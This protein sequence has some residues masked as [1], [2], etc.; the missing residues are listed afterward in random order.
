MPPRAPVAASAAALVAGAHFGQRYRIVRQLG[1]GGMG[2]VYQAWDEELGIPV[3]LKVIRPEV[4]SDPYLAQDVERRFKRELLLARKVTHS[5]VVRI[6]DLGEIDRIKYITMQYVEG[7][8]LATLIQRED[9]LPVPRALRIVRGVVSG[10]CA[11]HEAGVV[12][13]DLKPANIMIDEGDEARIM[14]F[15]IARSTTRASGPVTAPPDGA[16]KLFELRQQAAL[17]IPETIQGSVVGTVEYMAPEQ[18]RGE[19]VDQRADIYALGLIMYDM[20]GGAGRAARSESALVE[21]TARMEHQPPAIRSLNPE[22]PEA[23]ER[24]VARCLQPDANAR[25]ASSRDLEADLQRL[26]DVGNLL[27]VLRRVSTRQL[28]GA[29]ALTLSL[30]A[31]TWWFSRTPV[32]S[33][34]PAPVSVL[35]AD[36]E[37]RVGDPV[38][39]D[40]LEQA[41]G[42]ALEGA[43]FIVPYRRSD[44]RRIA[45]AQLSA[46]PTLDEKTA[47]LVAVREG[48]NVVLAGG[49]EPQG[50]GYQLSI[51]ALDTAN[52]KV[53]GTITTSAKSKTDVLAAVASSA[54]RIRKVLGDTTPESARLAAAETVTSTSLEAVRDYSRAQDLLY[55]SKD[56]EAIASYK[57][58]IAKD[59]N[60]GRAYSGWAIGA[61]NLGRRQEARDAWEKAVS[62][63]DRMTER[64]K[65]RT[66]GNY[67][68]AVPHNYEKA[69]ESLSTLV[70]LYPNDRGGQV[71]I[72]ISYFYL[73]NFA[74]ALDH[75]RRSVEIAPKDVMNRANYA[76]YAMYAGDFS[77]AAKEGLTVTTQNPTVY[78]AYLPL[79]MAAIAGSDFEGARKAY[80]AMAATGA[81]GASLANLGLADL[82]LYRGRPGEAEA[83]LRQGIAADTRRQDSAGLAA[84][85]TALAE[86]LLDQ[87]KT[88]PAV[89]P[90]RR[91]LAILGQTAAAVP[92]ARVLIAAGKPQDAQALAPVLA[93][94][95]QP[96]SRAYAK[97][98]DGELALRDGHLVAAT[99]AFGAAQK[100]TDIWWARLGLGTAYA[101]ANHNA[102]A[103][104]EFELCAKRRGEATAIMLD[105]LPSIRY[106]APLQYWLGRAH[107]GV[108][109]RQ[110]AMQNY[111]AYIALRA[112]NPNDPLVK[113]ARQRLASLSR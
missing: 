75:G 21:L 24:I 83:L 110:P 98:L 61:Q 94:E 25:Y 57:Q 38:F 55:N 86:A 87:G 26:D 108:R 64:E 66:L 82:A 16:T 109:Q 19:E 53:L 9:R 22:V 49:I 13:R 77:T 52:G 70:R 106:L 63:L 107:E 42:I 11:A 4:S 65:Y 33:P 102:E 71:N 12:H 67:Y 41:L 68:I 101:Q 47:R 103:L 7:V 93:E 111:E 34:E 112:A 30:L 62:L 32:A 89:D 88:S 15:G 113:D 39:T 80:E 81:P 92:A 37:N 96:E 50:S 10:L 58:A 76:L 35:V 73:R 8:D 1:S 97:L 36:F 45:A 74:K 43:S 85:Y 40:S 91:A 17:L 54:S 18:A 27:P 60:F 48:I 51:R 78:R 99:E 105:D 100:L 84:K 72:A 6:Y 104:G 59:P 23:C 31:G 56:E 90:A 5:H 20:L 79:A 29:S 46:G 95:L 3:A 69:I 2:V 14:D 28:V 44:A